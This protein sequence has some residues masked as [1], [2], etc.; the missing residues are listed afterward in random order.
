MAGAVIAIVIAATIFTAGIVAGVIAV[1]SIGVRR[2]EHD[3]AQTGRVSLTRQAPGRASM[4]GR[5]MTGLY[6]RQRADM[7]AAPASRQ[8]LLV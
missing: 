3:F 8:D 1:V 6:V 7:A 2:E 4:A 5:L